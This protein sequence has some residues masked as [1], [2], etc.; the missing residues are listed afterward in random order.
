MSHHAV[1]RLATGASPVM[2]W[3]V[4]L[5]RLKC[6]IKQLGLFSLRLADWAVLHTLI[7]HLVQIAIGLP[8]QAPAVSHI[9]RWI[10]PGSLILIHHLK[11]IVAY[12]I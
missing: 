4:L 1:L 10:H 9:Y 5:P 8:L 3:E 12:L 7:I 6:L 2:L 11:A